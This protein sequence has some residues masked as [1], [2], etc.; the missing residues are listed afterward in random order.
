MKKGVRKVE[1]LEF[2]IPSLLDFLDNRTSRWLEEVKIV[3]VK[4]SNVK[5]FIG[6]PTF[7]TARI[8]QIVT[9]EFTIYDL[10]LDFHNHTLSFYLVS[11][12]VP[13]LSSILQKVFQT[14]R[15]RNGKNKVGFFVYAAG[16]SRPRVRKVQAK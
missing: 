4:D 9:E 13:P 7:E 2:Y 15:V 11:E 10:H 12:K 5:Y 6:Y 14:F 3:G 8:Q 1:R 16:G